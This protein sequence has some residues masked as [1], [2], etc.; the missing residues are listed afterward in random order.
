L[1]PNLGIIFNAAKHESKNAND[2]ITKKNITFI[3][4]NPTSFHK[5]NGK[6]IPIIP[7][8]NALKKSKKYISNKSLLKKCAYLCAYPLSIN[9]YH[10]TEFKYL[11][12]NT[13][14]LIKFNGYIDKSYI[15]AHNPKNFLFFSKLSIIKRKN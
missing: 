14:F 10:Q 1:A 3:N 13:G 11:S 8:P 2:I 7:N 6:N 15:P 4:E 5:N 12:F 9:Q